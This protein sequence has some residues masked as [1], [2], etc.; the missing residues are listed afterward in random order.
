[1]G[2]STLLA[3]LKTRAF[4]LHVHCVRLLLSASAK[5]EGNEGTSLK[6]SSLVASN[7]EIAASG[8]M[9]CTGVLNLSAFHSVASSPSVQFAFCICS[10][11]QLYPRE[12]LR[13]VECAWRR[14]VQGGGRPGQEEWRRR[15]R[16][17]IGVGSC[18]TEMTGWSLCVGVLCFSG[19]CK[20]P[21][22]RTHSWSGRPYSYLCGMSDNLLSMF[23][24][25]DAEWVEV[26][27]ETDRE[28]SSSCG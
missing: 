8:R 20:S 18:W 3:I 11:G 1:M 23:E 19:T 13:S 25:P 17:Q 24:A 9:E 15:Q 22:G 26:A 21:R 6:T 12:P 14:S 4:F 27:T 28:I 7:L 5:Y 10:K 2:K 16:E